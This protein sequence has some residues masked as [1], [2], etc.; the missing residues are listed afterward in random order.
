[1]R[2]PDEILLSGGEYAP[3]PVSLV[4]ARRPPGES[5]EAQKY[6]AGVTEDFLQ[7]LHIFN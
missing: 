2:D 4:G 6:S 1:M 5:P 3:R 7:A